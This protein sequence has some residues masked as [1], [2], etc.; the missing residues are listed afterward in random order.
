MGFFS[1][2]LNPKKTREKELIDNLLAEVPVERR[3][4][5]TIGKPVT[6]TKYTPYVN[7]QIVKHKCKKKVKVKFIV[8]NHYILYTK[9]KDNSKPIVREFECKKFIYSMKGIP[10]NV[11]IM[12]Q[13]YGPEGKK[14]TLDKA[15]CKDYHLKWEPGLEI[16]AMEMFWIPKK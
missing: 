6:V 16:F 15:G 13:V 7:K 4:S 14:Y 11:V 5:E 8:G 10:M 2:L 12:K 3:I 9:P 1:K